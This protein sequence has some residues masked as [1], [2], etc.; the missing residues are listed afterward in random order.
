MRPLEAPCPLLYILSCT[1]RQVPVRIKGRQDILHIYEED[2]DFVLS[3]TEV[4]ELVAEYTHSLT[5]AFGD[6]SDS[7]SSEEA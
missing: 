6:A 2:K 1:K 5:L 3:K 4:E 7:E